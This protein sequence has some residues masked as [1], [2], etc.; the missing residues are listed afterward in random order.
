MNPSLPR[1]Y[2]EFA[3]WFHLLTAPQEYAEDAS[4]YSETLVST[5][6]GPVRTLLELGSG[7]GNVASHLKQQFTLTLVDLSPDMVE[8]SRIINPE[9]EHITGDMRSIRLGHQFDAVLI[10][11]AISYMTTESD[12]RSALT[13][14]FAHLR[15]GGAAIFAP[16]HIWETF[17]PTT[18]CGGYDGPER[19]LRYLEWL[20]DPDPTD[21]IYTQDFA[22]LFRERDGTVHAEQD[23]HFM[24]LFSRDVWLQTLREVGF[25]AR[26]LPFDHSEMPPSTHEIF[27]AS[28]L[29]SVE[30]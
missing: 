14:A 6:D 25:D 21:S 18:D 27:L 7:G 10:Q 11:D 13:T 8:V 26:A 1:L 20:W 24:G 30:T 15:V 29:A 9:V 28:K 16:D 22:Y 5:C 12:L 23:R 19:A 3:P 2:H 17:Q 4:F